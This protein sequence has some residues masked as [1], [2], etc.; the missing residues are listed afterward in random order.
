VKPRGERGVKGADAILMLHAL[1]LLCGALG[2]AVTGLAIFVTTALGLMV[3]L[4]GTDW[5]QRPP[6]GHDPRTQG[7]R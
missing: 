2:L 1:T 7:Q 5:A 3:W 6:A 4:A